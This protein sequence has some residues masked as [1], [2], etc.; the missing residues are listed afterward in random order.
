MPR[1]HKAS[2][3]AKETQKA[4]M[5]V[6]LRA[7]LGKPQV[8]IQFTPRVAVRCSNFPSSAWRE[9][10]SRQPGVCRHRS[11]SLPLQLV[12]VCVLFG[13]FLNRTIHE[14]KRKSESMRKQV[15]TYLILIRHKSA[16]SQRIAA[17]FVSLFF[18]HYL[19][20]WR[21]HF[22]V[23]PASYTVSPSFLFLFFMC[24]NNLFSLINDVNPMCLFFTLEPRERS[25]GR[26]TAKSHHMYTH[27][28]ERNQEKRKK[29]KT[30]G[31][32]QL[33]L[34]AQLRRRRQRLRGGRLEQLL[35]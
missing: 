33:W 2:P 7:K 20:W 31:T 12:L 1:Q 16:R 29:R 18:F 15:D 35:A 8:R 23:V 4:K 21:C 27:N 34:L 26:E 6:L 5:T 17:P 13:S 19:F 28:I 11:G 25:G 32:K 14:K 9:K 3:C 30:T 24:L 22:K 10:R